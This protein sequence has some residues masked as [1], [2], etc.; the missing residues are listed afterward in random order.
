MFLREA[1]GHGVGFFTI[2]DNYVPVL[3]REYRV[4]LHLVLYKHAEVI[5][6]LRA[7]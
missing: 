2:V 6:A 4:P 7:F 1:A 3:P 5:P